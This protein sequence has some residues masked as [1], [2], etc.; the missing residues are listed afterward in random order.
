V[1][2]KNHFIAKQ[3]VNKQQ[4]TRHIHYTLSDAKIVATSL[5]LCPHIKL[6]LISPDNMER[7]FAHDEIQVI[8]H[9]TPY[10]TFCWAGGHALAHHISCQPQD[11][12]NKT[13]LDFGSGSGVVAIAAAKA[14]AKRVI[15]CDIDLHALDAVRA[16][17]ALNHVHVDVCTTIDEVTEKLDLII[18][19]DVLYDQS[20]FYLINEFLTYAPEFLVADSR[21]NKITSTSYQKVAEITA[22]TIPDLDDYE[23]HK[24]VALYRAKTG[25]L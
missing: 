4:L 6:H 2:D 25:G 9:N 22:T 10:W 3:L 1:F 20:N 5:P 7:P 11:F 19:A 13:I 24:K 8:L 18:A 23:A 14:N 16:N 21:V 17:A 12:A 15:A